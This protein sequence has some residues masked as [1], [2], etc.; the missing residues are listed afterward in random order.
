M[1]SLVLLEQHGWINTRGSYSHGG[2]HRF[3]AMAHSNSD[4]NIDEAVSD[5]R[6]YQFEPLLG[7][8]SVV[9]HEDS[10]DSDIDLERL[11]QHS[12]N[13]DRLTNTTW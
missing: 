2:K 8:A 6:P 10:S 9:F 13:Q 7:T 3:I 5:I 11:D 1:T 4:V 12:Q